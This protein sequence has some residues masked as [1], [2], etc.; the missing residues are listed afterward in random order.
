M[1]FGIPPWL[2]PLVVFALPGLLLGALSVSS[3]HAEEN[4]TV[5]LTVYSDYV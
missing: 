5:V 1:R 2:G 4:R 3:L